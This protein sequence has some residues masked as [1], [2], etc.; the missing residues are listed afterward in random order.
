LD[1]IVVGIGG[2]LILV[3]FVG[4]QIL[5]LWRAGS[6]YDQIVIKLGAIFAVAPYLNIAAPVLVLVGSYQA[7]ERLN[8]PR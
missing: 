7:K 1:F 6:R 5:G 8:L 4:G 3:G 2:L